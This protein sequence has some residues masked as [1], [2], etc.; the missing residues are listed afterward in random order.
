MPGARC[1]RSLACKIKKHTSVVTTGSPGSPGIPARN[2]FNSLY[3]ALPGD[4]AWLSPSPAEMTSAN[5]TPA[6]RRQDHTTSP[7]ASVLFVSRTS[8]SIASRPAVVTIASAPDVGRDGPG[9]G[10]D[11]PD[12]ESQIFLPMGLDRNFAQQLIC[13]SGAL[14]FRNSVPCPLT[15]QIDRLRPSRSNAGTPGAHASATTT[16]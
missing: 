13:P 7:S 6:S 14:A 2:G 5:L 11:L 4:R 3:R 16:R 10:F 8:A 9:Y 1:T 15:S 12:G